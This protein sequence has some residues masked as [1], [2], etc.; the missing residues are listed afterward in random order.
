VYEPNGAYNRLFRHEIHSL[1]LLHTEQLR[2]GKS[3]YDAM[4]LVCMSSAKSS[5]C[6]E[7]ILANPEGEMYLANERV[8]LQLL[9]PFIELGSKQLRGICE[10][11]SD[12]LASWLIIED[13]NR[14]SLTRTDASMHAVDLNADMHLDAA[15]GGD[16]EMHDAGGGDAKHFVMMGDEGG[17]PE[18]TPSDGQ[19]APFLFWN[20]L[21][22][23]FLN[24]IGRI[25]PDLVFMAKLA[26]IGER[27]G[28]Q[29]RAEHNRPGSHHSPAPQPPRNGLP[30][31]KVGG[32]AA[33]AQIM[34][35]ALAQ[36]SSLSGK[37]FL[38]PATK[39]G[40]Q[41]NPVQTP[42]NSNVG[43]RDFFA[44]LV[45][46]LRDPCAPPP[47]HAA[48]LRSWEL[49]ENQSESYGRFL[50][51]IGYPWFLRQ[52]LGRAMSKI[53]AVDAGEHVVVSAC[54]KPLQPYYK[55]ATGF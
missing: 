23:A 11:H 39:F 22:V 7:S 1:S 51:A 14:D 19:A 52:F 15:E 35:Y 38:L 4:M 40:S 43:V 3:F 25:N 29:A 54:G 46:Q 6:A 37:S 13:K 53:S 48:L 47:K 2:T 45:P 17:G 27:C 30:I 44:Q 28:W 10:L 33:R 55:P 34:H 42:C 49:I 21:T 32:G 5:A 18:H 41:F 36:T 26:E 16:A 24:H 9:Q 8:M 12:S 20:T 50:A 31:S